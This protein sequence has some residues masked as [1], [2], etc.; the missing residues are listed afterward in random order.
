MEETLKREEDK[1]NAKEAKKAKAKIQ[2]L[3]GCD[4][5][6]VKELLKDPTI[7]WADLFN[8][9]REC[10]LR[11]VRRLCDD[12]IMTPQMMVDVFVIQNAVDPAKRKL[13]I[14]TLW[15]EANKRRIPPLIV[16]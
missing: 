1:A 4:A 15:Q 2:N 3:S 7:G 10:W 12:E 16:S 11:L 8:R 6:R 14:E 9:N 13:A 5:K